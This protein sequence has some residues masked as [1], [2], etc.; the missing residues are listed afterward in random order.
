MR[1][2][3]ARP[4]GAWRSEVRQ[5]KGCKQPVPHSVSAVP[6]GDSYHV[7]GLGHAWRGEAEHGDAR[8]GEARAVNSGKRLTGRL[9]KRIAS[10]S[11]V[12]LGM[13]LP[14]RVRYGK[15]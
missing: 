6:G 11:A 14:G 7:A 13:A 8:P 4:G 5:G 2:G 3:E 15:G 9:P 12:G 1:R 10:L